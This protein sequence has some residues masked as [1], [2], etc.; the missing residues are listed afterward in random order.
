MTAASYPA[1]LLSVRVGR[2]ALIWLTPGRAYKFFWGNGAG[3][4]YRHELETFDCARACSVWGE[5]LL[6]V[7]RRLGPRL[8]RSARGKMVVSGGPNDD[9]LLSF[10]EERLRAAAAC[11]APQPA[12]QLTELG[13]LRAALEDPASNALIDRV[14][15]QLTPLMLPAGPVHGDLHRGNIVEVDGRHFVI[16]CNRFNPRSAPLF[17]RIHFLMTERKLRSRLKWLEMLGESD[18]LIASAMAADGVGPGR[19]QDVALAYGANR[20]AL[21][22]F[23]AR[24]EGRPVA[25]YRRMIARLIEKFGDGQTASG[26]RRVA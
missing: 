17:D 9:A 24:L 12:S 5:Q 23:A 8:L 13:K 10:V 16:D 25:K 14:E 15:W 26:V 2:A 22:A 20:L 21:E 7:D 6:P 18:D 3:F 19:L 1:G 4:R 11:H